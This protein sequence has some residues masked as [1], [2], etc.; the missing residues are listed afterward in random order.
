MLFSILNEGSVC[1]QR[2]LSIFGRGVLSGG[3]I[4]QWRFIRD[5]TSYAFTVS[6][7]HAA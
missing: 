5:S 7:Y 2:R 4:F 1:L 6:L 3:V